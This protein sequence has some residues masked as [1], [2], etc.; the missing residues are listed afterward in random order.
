[1]SKGS[2]I[3]KGIANDLKSIPVSLKE[4][5][6]GVDAKKLF[7]MNM[8][9]IFAGYFC[10]KAAWLWRVSP[11]QD[12]FAKITAFMETL[13]S[14]FKNPLP[15]FYPKDLLAGAGF[16]IALRLVV[17]FKTKNAKKFRQGAEYGSAR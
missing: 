8:P 2:I 14:L 4:K 15:S 7:L 17:H 6:D 9:Y 16:G 13:D 12:V 5:A 11:G 3:L 1:M 10:D